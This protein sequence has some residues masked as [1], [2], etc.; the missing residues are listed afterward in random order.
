M[1]DRQR[2]QYGVA[3]AAHSH[4]KHQSVVE[5]GGSHEISGTRS[6]FHFC[7]FHDAERG[8]APEFHAFFGVCG[9]RAVAG[10]G[11]TEGFAEAVHAVGGEH[12]RAGTCAGAGG[13]FQIFQFGIVD[14]ADAVGGDTLKNRIQVGILG[15]VGT[16]AGTHRAAGSEKGRDVQTHC[17]HD[18][19]GNDL[20]TVRDADHC[21]E[22]MSRAHGFHAV[23][24]DFAAGEGV[25]HTGV[26]HGDTVTDGD[27]VELIRNAAGFADGVTDDFTDLFQMAMSGD[28]VGIG[29]ADTDKGFLDVF[30]GDPGRTHQPAVGSAFQTFFHNITSHYK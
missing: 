8:F 7:H 15:A 14:L 6:I 21:I 20:V 12:T 30:R 2:V 24:D 28:D 23:S 16:L 29:V 3:A 26:P 17:T 10:E 1:S 25:F 27:R 4:I 5:G 9:D 19:T 11:E 13:A 22:R 18:H